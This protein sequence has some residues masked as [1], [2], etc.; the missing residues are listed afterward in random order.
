MSERKN[1]PKEERAMLHDV[2]CKYELLLNG[3]LGTWTTKNVDIEGLFQI[4]IR[5]LFPFLL[6]KKIH[7]FLLLMRTRTF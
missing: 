3:A 4:Q 7:R 1:L 5:I 6:T 2:L